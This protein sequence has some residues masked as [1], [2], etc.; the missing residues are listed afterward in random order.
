MA[1]EMRKTPPPKLELPAVVGEP[2]KVVLPVPVVVE[3]HLPLVASHGDVVQRP[4]KL[5]PNRP[6]HQLATIPQ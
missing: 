4:W 2:A 1:V 3:D 6:S 5:N